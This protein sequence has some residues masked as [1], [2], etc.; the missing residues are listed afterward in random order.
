[1]SKKKLTVALVQMAKS[2]DVTVKAL[3]P[4]PVESY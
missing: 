3:H 1:M 4:F 2:W